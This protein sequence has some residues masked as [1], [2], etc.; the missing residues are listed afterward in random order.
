MSAWVI[1]LIAAG[2]LAGAEL[3][4]L[5]LVLLMLAGGALGGVATALV[6]LPVIA[7]LGAFIIVALGLL[8]FVR[9]IAKRHLTSR[10]PEQID[11]ADVY[12]GRVG[13]VTEPVD[14]VG[15]RI[16]LGGD[17]WSAVSEAKGQ[18]FEVGQSVR[19]ME[20]RGATA[21]VAESLD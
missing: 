12:V 14:H 21:I 2:V 3:L 5:D 15:G 1:W 10:T 7:Q 8:V 18:T 16:K 6:G 17:V 4:T 9:P 19:I 13:I 11:G 20:V